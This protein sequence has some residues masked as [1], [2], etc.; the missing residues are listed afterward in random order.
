MTTTTAGK[1]RR[2]E[3]MRDD[4]AEAA[5]R[6]VTADGLDAVSIDRLCEEAG[7]AR[8]T[9][10]AHFPDGRD[11][12][13]REAYARAGQ[14]L[15]TLAH[16][17]AASCVSWDEQIVSYARTMLEFSS[18]RTLGHF[19]SVSG[20]ALMGFRESGGEG[21]RGYQ[22]AIRAEL[23]AARD[24]ADLVDGADPDIL[25]VLLASSLR[26]AG[27]ATAHRPELAERFI[28]GIELILEGLRARARRP[29]E[30]R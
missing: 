24:A 17:R 9:V 30:E 4:V 16:D 27:I 26:D 22:E 14:M 13:L 19:Y 1:A 28:S 7:V 18:T 10:Y 2:R 15:L 25:A 5:L 11:G 6:V 8:A 21:T 23:A 3:R 12:I 29:M 20:P